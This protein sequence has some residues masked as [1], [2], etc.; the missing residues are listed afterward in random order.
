MATAI[1]APH[2]GETAAH[3]S[4]L[5]ADSPVAERPIEA[6]VELIEATPP[7]APTRYPGMWLDRLRRPDSAALS[8]RD[9][10]L[11]TVDPLSRVRS[12]QR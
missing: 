11:A 7:T 6:P 2:T 1:H 12:I 10:V 4:T 5:V 8:P 9:L 3:R